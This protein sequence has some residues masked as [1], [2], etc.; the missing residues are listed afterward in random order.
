MAIYMLATIRRDFKSIVGL[1]LYDTDE[2]QTKDFMLPGIIQA[3]NQNT[4]IENVGLDITK[5]NIVG[6]NGT[7]DRYVKVIQGVGIAGKSSVVVIKEYAN[8][9]Y[10]V[11]NGNGQS[12]RM[13]A[14]SLIQYGLTEGIAN[15]TIVNN[16]TGDAFI[17]SI[18]GQFEQEVVK[19]NEVIRKRLEAKINL[20][21]DSAKF[22]LAEDGR[23][24]Q[25][26]KEV[27]KVRVNLGVEVLAHKA[28]ANCVNLEEL[29]LPSS[30]RTIGRAAFYNCT[31]LKTLKIPYGMTEFNGDEFEM[32][33]IE[34]LY[35][36]A[37]LSNV[38]NA[39]MIAPRLKVVYYV[40]RNMRQKLTVKS[41]VK[42]EFIAAY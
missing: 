2:K 6:L 12:C 11:V 30:I 24:T 10:E 26:D 1:R 18:S 23:Y 33:A 29:I 21:T 38:G 8:G 39:L 3:L 36:P 34:T 17:R 41:G 37:S 42:R 25:L 32:S 4:V 14:E 7:L 16:G 19:D 20:V 9:E 22:K 28:F 15:A 27:K 31:K 5:E 35:I 13:S 40:D